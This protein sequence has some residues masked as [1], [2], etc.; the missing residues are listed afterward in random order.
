[1]ID[2]SDPAFLQDPYPVLNAVREE[3]PIFHQQ[4]EDGIERWFLTR[5]ED[6]FRALRDRRLGRVP[7][8]IM[9]RAEVGLPPLRADW[10]PYNDVEQWSLLMLEPP[11]H[12]RLRQLVYRE[13]TPKRIEGLRPAIARHADRLLRDAAAQDRFDLLSDF[14]QPF[15]IHV[16]AELLGAPIEDWPRYLDWSH[17][18]VKMYELDTTDDQATSAVQASA[19][20]ASWCRDLIGERRARPTNDLISGLCTVETSDGRLSDSEIIST[21]VL[22]LN[23]GHEATVNSLGNGIVSMLATPE[24][25]ESVCSGQTAPRTAV[26]EM[27][28]FDPPLQLFERWV[29]AD[30]VSYAGREFTRGE[31]IA[32]LFGSANRDPR[33]FDDPDEFIVDRGDATHITFGGGIHTCIGAP[34][35]RLELSVALERMTALMPDLRLAEPPQRHPAFVI[36]GYEAVHLEA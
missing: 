21:I 33:H 30:G 19:E 25:W 24:A 14:A 15:S 29:L 32:M 27:I 6:V 9:T 5:Y 26:E 36:H 31:K 35:A 34:L 16:I 8:P 7:E 1:M 11:E 28:R 12:R 10:G 20:F 22:L 13:F 18:I 17:R 4:G 2:F 23:A 3:T